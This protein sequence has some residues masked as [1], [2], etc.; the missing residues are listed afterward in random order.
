MSDH[1]IQV[2]LRVLCGLAAQPPREPDPSDV[3]RLRRAV[4]GEP[5]Y[6]Y[7]DD[8]A[9][10]LLQKERTRLKTRAAAA[11]CSFR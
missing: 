5:K 4:S 6:W 11:F 7:V 10:Y 2:A 1:L 9:T 8:L 3:E